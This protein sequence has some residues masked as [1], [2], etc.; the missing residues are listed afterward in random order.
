AVMVGN[1]FFCSLAGYGLAK[2]RFPYRMLCFVLILSTLMLPLEI[3][4]VPT[5]LVARELGLVNNYG[6]L[7]IPLLVDAFRIFLMRQYIKN[8]PDSL[9][10]AARFDGCRQ[11][12][13]FWPH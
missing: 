9:I 1:V 10:E 12:A 11:V 7:I 8:L 4:L 5:Y 6:G 3:M 13:N 2:F